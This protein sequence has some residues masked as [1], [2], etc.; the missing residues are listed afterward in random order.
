MPEQLH[1]Y[2]V[3]DRFSPDRCTVVQA[4]NE[5]EAKDKA[6]LVIKRPKAHFVVEF[7]RDCVAS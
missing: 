2:R 5:E 4:Q 6:A 3:Y 7:L 1:Y